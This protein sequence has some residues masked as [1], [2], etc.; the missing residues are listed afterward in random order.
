MTDTQTRDEADAK[1][2]KDKSIKLRIIYNGI[3]RRLEV[4]ESDP[5]TAVLA[6][7]IGLFTVT[8]AQHLL[9]LFNTD[10][11]ELTNETQSAEEAGL[12]NNTRLVLRQSAVKGG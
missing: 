8:E 4:K 10:G 5:I 12:K 2:P 6:A 11:V 7:A 9:A 1:A 3:E